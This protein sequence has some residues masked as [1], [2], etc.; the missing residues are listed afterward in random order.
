MH[1][2]FFTGIVIFGAAGIHIFSKMGKG[3]L[4][5]NVSLVYATG[6]A[7][8]VS[9]AFLPF[10]AD[11]AVKGSFGN[12][13]IVLSCLV[14]ACITIAHFGIFYMY[15]AGAPITIAM[16]LVRFAPVAL[17]VIA[18]FFMFGE[19]LKMQ[20]ICGLALALLAVVFLTR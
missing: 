8:L 3:Y 6:A 19:T 16:P 7:F 17:A 2:L 15:K 4:D 12:K 9:L 5:P 18:G 14:G 1:W 11:G 20:H 10:A 13:G